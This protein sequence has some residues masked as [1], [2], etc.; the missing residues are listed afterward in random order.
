MGI[1]NQYYL[2]FN[3]EM[4]DETHTGSLKG[5][6]AAL[7]RKQGKKKKIYIS[8]SLNISL[9]ELQLHAFL[10]IAMGELASNG[11]VEY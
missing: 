3:S 4:N 5:A 7:K 6:A 8:P 10:T 2:G 9:I 1:D 11:E